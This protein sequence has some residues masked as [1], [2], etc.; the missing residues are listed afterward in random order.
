MNDRL[1]VSASWVRFNINIYYFVIPYSRYT[2]TASQFRNM[3]TFT[4]FELL[5]SIEIAAKKK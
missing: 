3:N 5:K 4:L 1:W 2:L